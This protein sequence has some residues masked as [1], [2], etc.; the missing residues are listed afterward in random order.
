MQQNQWSPPSEDWVKVNVEAAMDEQNNIAGLG[1]VIR[2]HRGEVVAAAAN[3]VKS[4]GDVEM[5]EAKAALWGIQVPIKAGASSIL[6]ESDSKRVTVLINSKRS[7][8]TELFWVIF[9]ILEAK[10]SFQNFKAQHVVRTCNTLA[11]DLTK[12][13]LRKSESCIWL[14]EFPAEILYLFSS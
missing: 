7:T 8:L 3:I 4:Y 2:N 1:A 14:D 10:K 11:Y 13:A 9:D 5:S 6:L 12:L